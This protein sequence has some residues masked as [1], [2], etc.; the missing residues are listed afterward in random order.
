[1]PSVEKRLE[2][3]GEPE[4]PLI[5]FAENEREQLLGL[6]EQLGMP[7][8]SQE[9]RLDLA[10]QLKLVLNENGQAYH[11]VAEPVSEMFLLEHPPPLVS[12]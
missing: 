4:K 7:E 12:G 2:L 6:A 1:M 3:A 11:V 5:T 8:V 9:K 10:M